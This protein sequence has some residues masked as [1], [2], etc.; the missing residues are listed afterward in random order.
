MPTYPGIINLLSDD[1]F[2]FQEAKSSFAL[3]HPSVVEKPSSVV[4]N[5]FPTQESDAMDEESY[6]SEEEH[7][8][9]P[10]LQRSYHAVAPAPLPVSLPPSVRPAPP[11]RP[12]RPIGGSRFR[13]CQWTEQ[14]INEMVEGKSLSRADAELCRRY[15]KWEKEDAEWIKQFGRN[16][17]DAE[18]NE[19]DFDE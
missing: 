19:N 12:Q 4:V 17:E 11:R 7:E 6:E 16:S 10:R 14:E 3:S 9:T 15:Q 1:P 18:L 8:E 13:G 5:L 2:E